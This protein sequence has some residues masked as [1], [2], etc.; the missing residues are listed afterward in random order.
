[1]GAS[2]P[3]DDGLSP[4]IPIFD[5]EHHASYV[6]HLLKAINNDPPVHNIALAG[7]YGTG[8]SSILQGVKA[9]LQ[10]NNS[11]NA[12]TPLIEI[13][14]SS[15]NER[16]EKVTEASGESSLTAV[17]QKEIVKRLL[18]SQSP[19]KLSLS[20]FKRIVAFRRGRALGVAVLVVA[21]VWA[22]LYLLF[23]PSAIGQYFENRS[24]SPW[25]G[26][27]LGSLIVSAALFVIQFLVHRHAV[28]ELSIGSASIKISDDAG[29]YFDEY[30]EEILYFFKQTRT[31][32]VIFED[33]DRF[34]D[35]NIFQALRDLNTLLN[36]ARP[37]EQG[38]VF[39]YAVRDSLFEPEADDSGPNPGASPASRGTEP[40]VEPPNS[41]KAKPKSVKHRYGVSA[42][43]SDRSKFFD[44]IIPVVPFISPDVSANLLLRELNKKQVKDEARPSTDL[45]ALAGRYFTDMRVIRSIANEYQVYANELLGKTKLT[46]LCPDKQLAMVLYKHAYLADYERIRSGDSKLDHVAK[47]VREIT[48]RRLKAIDKN[49]AQLRTEA[50]TL[51]RISERSEAM[52]ERAQRLLQVASK[53]TGYSAVGT[54]RLEP[55][56]RSFQ[57]DEL[58]TEAFWTAY[59]ARPGSLSVY[60][61]QRLGAELSTEDIKQFVEEPSSIAAWPIRT[62]KEID[63]RVQAL[64]S[65]RA[66]ITASTFKERVTDSSLWDSEVDKEI[67]D[68]PSCVHE[69]LGDGLALELVRAGHLDNNFALYASV[70][71]GDL[72]SADA[73]S[74]M[75]QVMD[76]HETDPDYKLSGEDVKAILKQP[77]YDFLN[78]RSALNISVFEH[79]IDDDRLDTTLRKIVTGTLDQDHAFVNTFIARS[80]A[81]TKLV[82]HLSPNFDKILDVIAT[83]EQLEPEPK[84]HLLSTALGHLSSE[85]DY[86]ASDATLELTTE[87][88]DDLPVIREDLT[89]ERSNAF[90]AFLSQNSI[91]LAS[92]TEMRE[93]AR[94]AVV[95]A[96]AFEVNLPNLMVIT[97]VDGQVGIDTLI[98]A[99]E[100]LVAYLLKDAD[101]YLGA[102]KSAGGEAFS[103]DD[104]KRLTEVLTLTANLKGDSLD[105]L[106]T[107]AHPNA[108]VEQLT[109]APETSWP[110][111]ARTKRFAPTVDNLVTYLKREDHNGSYGALAQSL[112]TTTAILSASEANEADKIDLGVWLVNQEL[113]PNPVKLRLLSQLGPGE[114]LPLAQLHINDGQLLAGLISGGR[115]SDAADTFR[116]FS[117]LPW[118]QKELALAG[119]TR[120]PEFV[121]HLDLHADE[122]EAIMQSSTFSRDTKTAVLAGLQSL[123]GRGIL[124]RSLATVLADYAIAEK[125]SVPA[126]DLTTLAAQGTPSY[127]IA[128]LLGMDIESR[129]NEEILRVLNQLRGEYRKLAVAGGKRPRLEADEDV[130]RLLDKLKEMDLVSRYQDETEDGKYLRVI[131]RQHQR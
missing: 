31:R 103:V 93:G 125:L 72:L 38:V 30:L 52:G 5:D 41:T 110:S 4:L 32:Y 131:M 70:Y 118:D 15:L 123:H 21:A 127:R 119:S 61:G 75:L 96:N 69:I 84:L 7:A 115:I 25:F 49:I 63:H 97:P 12:R 90:A 111:L 98:G 54:V 2:K 94:A 45:I 66:R 14:L 37:T 65:L 59:A 18:Y 64:R 106:L 47:K 48:D 68:L 17:L 67:P 16:P 71:Y 11:R 74:F 51:S 129:D 126:G 19:S 23:G 91:K 44:L 105:K 9:S 24:I 130:R 86:E 20:R 58:K 124:T 102:L 85:L 6:A 77:G 3:L 95:E 121:I 22:V 108:S 42:P 107:L 79:L 55:G 8:K 35:P 89:L 112:A 114:P 60:H 53:N 13:S 73:R 36:T 80:E 26:G 33:L 82:Q 81:A 117:A 28:L 78:T 34:N 109:D 57:W 99:G 113:V 100:S 83:N 43:A 128:K 40:T 92:I 29:T 87:S 27:A 101:A 46:G 122:F 120:L 104:P 76:Q 62:Q 88:I 50:A 39:I 1:M 56:G 116:R 10:S